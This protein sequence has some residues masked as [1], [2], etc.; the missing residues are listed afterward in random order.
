[1]SDKNWLVFQLEELLA[2]VQPGEVR[3]HEF[4]RSP[5]LSCSVYHI[6]AGSKEMQSA[7]VEDE[8]YLVLEGR[9][10]LRVETDDHP[11]EKGTLLYVKAASEHTFFEVE[12]DLTVLAFFGSASSLKI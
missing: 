5:S 9:G 4:L 2:K 1:M 8:L 3:L 7:H 6:P 10:R 12:E 11:V